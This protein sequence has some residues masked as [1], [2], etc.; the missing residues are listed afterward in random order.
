MEVVKKCRDCQF[1]QKQMTKHVNPLRSIDISWPFAVWG[2]DIVDIL[3]RAPGSFRYL[4]VGINTFTKWMQAV[5]VVNITQE[6]T[7]KFLQSIIYK[8]S[9]PK[10]VLT[11]NETQF[12]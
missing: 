1:F 6:A 9:V 4:F 7:V 11:D 12:K 5:P 8:F 2:I 3:S 10:S